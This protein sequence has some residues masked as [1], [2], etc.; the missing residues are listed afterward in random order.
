M[1]ENHDPRLRSIRLI[2]GISSFISFFSSNVY[3]IGNNSITLID[4][5]DETATC[6]WLLSAFREV[7]LNVNNVI[8]TIITHSHE[9]HWGGLARL[10][11]MT[12]LTVLVYIEDV[13]YYQ[14][15]LNLLET[16]HKYQIRGLRDGDIVEAEGRTLTVLHTPGHD[17][18]SICLYDAANR[19][20]FSGDTVF[21]SGTTGSLRSG[22]LA[23]LTGSLRRLTTLD[24]DILL[25]GHGN[26]VFDKADEVITLALKRTMRNSEVP[27][28]SLF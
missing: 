9:D 7:N 4:A 1:L 26:L 22:N 11:Q 14:K 23:D 12:S 25:P 15:E 13:S 28:G 17:G 20:L 10:L 8:T 27:D 21:A 3:S 19:I 6:V 2:S 16:P 5:G 18:G 24:V